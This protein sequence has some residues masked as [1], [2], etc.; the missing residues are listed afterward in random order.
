LDPVLKTVLNELISPSA[1]SIV[2]D[3]QSS[4]AHFFVQFT[5]WVNTV[6][7]HCIFDGVK[8]QFIC[9]IVHYLVASGMEVLF[10]QACSYS[11]G[12]QVKMFITKVEDW[13]RGKVGQE[14]IALAE[15]ELEPMRQAA[16][17]LCLLQ[18]S[19]LA[20]QDFREAVCAL[21]RPAH[22][23]LILDGYRGDQFDKEPVPQSLINTISKQEPTYKNLPDT[24]DPHHPKPLDFLF[25]MSDLNLDKL[26]LPKVILDKPA[27]SFLKR[28]AN[29]EQSKVQS[30]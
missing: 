1:L 7:R 9:R 16:N 5:D 8:K 4:L 26:A 24:F 19:D 14:F 11:M 13:V 2:Q 17:I 28:A 10:T 23:A 21:L 6:A 3:D 20:K 29:N 22:I 15:V 30:W 25:L 18:K 12:I 27:F